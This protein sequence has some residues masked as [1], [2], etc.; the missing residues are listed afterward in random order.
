MASRYT[1]GIIS[2]NKLLQILYGLSYNKTLAQKSKFSVDQLDAVFGGE[3]SVAYGDNFSMATFNRWVREEMAYQLTDFANACKKDTFNF[4]DFL[5][6]KTTARNKYYQINIT[7]QQEIGNINREM[8][9][10][11]GYCMKTTAAIQYAAE[12]ALI[13]LGAFVS[14]PTTLW[15]LGRRVVVGVGAG[16]SIMVAENW[17][18]ARH[19]D[20]LVMPSNAEIDSNI[21]ANIPSILKDFN[22]VC[23]GLNKLSF[24]EIEKAVALADKQIAAARRALKDTTNAAVKAGIEA[25]IRTIKAQQAKD[26]SMLNQ[27]KQVAAAPKPT[28]AAGVRDFKVEAPRINNTNLSTTAKTVNVGLNVVCWALVVKSTYDST[29]KFARHWQGNL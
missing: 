13:G 29:T 19:A 6:K 12:M 10:I 5:E 21:S 28:Y 15:M 16:L 4:T 1:V 17:S 18:Q 3:S 9:D 22:E 20:M 14:P 23:N 2:P 11:Y 26:L 8:S 24:I 7:A 27:L 25:D